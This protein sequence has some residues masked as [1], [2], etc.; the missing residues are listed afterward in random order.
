V[1]EAATRPVWVA[2]PGTARKAPSHRSA[3][4]DP[5]RTVVLL[6]HLASWIQTATQGVNDLE[7]RRHASAAPGELNC[8]REHGADA[9]G[10][11]RL[12]K[13]VLGLDGI[14]ERIIGARAPVA[15]PC[16]DEVLTQ[17]VARDRRGALVARRV[18][19][20]L[21][22]AADRNPTRIEGLALYGA[23]AGV[24]ACA[25]V[26]LPDHDEVAHGARG[27]APHTWGK[28]GPRGGG[29]DLELSA[30][31]GAAGVVALALDGP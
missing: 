14:P 5:R 26:A 19:V 18:G 28:L 15:L 3:P 25:C 8:H 21:E 11:R 16:Y 22:L 23:P 2:L 24:G 20:D 17:R 12:G 29:I 4:F 31:R 1:R 13:V 30:H 27:V 7:R 9:L 6:W 10:D